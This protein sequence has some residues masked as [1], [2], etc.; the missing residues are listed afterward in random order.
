MATINTPLYAGQTGSVASHPA[1]TLVQ[2]KLRLATV[3]I[4]SGTVLT[5]ADKVNLVKLPVGARVLPA[6]SITIKGNATAVLDLGD[7]TTVDC[8]AKSVTAAAR[9]YLSAFGAKADAE[10]AEGN[11]TVVA[12]VTTG[13]T[14]ATD[15]TIYIA[16]VCV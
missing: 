2:G 16:Y 10:I 9:A 8:Y 12:T 13:A 15:W 4:P 14:L 6:S 7:G 3:T 11:D 5:A 1:S